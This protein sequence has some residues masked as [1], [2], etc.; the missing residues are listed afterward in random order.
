M[1]QRKKD[2]S[3]ICLIEDNNDGKVLKKNLKL[4]FEQSSRSEK[5]NVRFLTV[6]IN[7]GLFIM[8]SNSLDNKL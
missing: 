4:K 2:K 3:R 6:D 7:L 5:F 8:I 1:Q